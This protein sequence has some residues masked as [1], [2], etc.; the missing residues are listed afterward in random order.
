MTPQVDSKVY[1]TGH[2][3]DDADRRGGRS[4]FSRATLRYYEQL[5]LVPRTAAGNREYDESVL[6]RLAFI[7]R[8]KVLGCTLEEI[9]ELMPDA[10]LNPGPAP[11]SPFL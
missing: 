10:V 8:A 11:R 9:A 1:P 6:A 7:A 2:D 4:D 3:N 5:D